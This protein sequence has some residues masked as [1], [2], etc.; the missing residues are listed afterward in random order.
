VDAATRARLKLAVDERRR[1]LLAEFCHP[2]RGSRID[3]EW[4]AAEL[5][6]AL[7]KAGIHDRVRPF[8]DLRHTA[9]TN[10]A[11]AGASELAV[12]AKAG[13]QHVDDEDLPAPGRG[14]L[15][16]GGRGA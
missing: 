5:R 12:M 4:F 1:V 16:R 3:A 10:D 15:P 11:A 2:K 13:Q 8:H 6:S 9:I 14:R 7:A